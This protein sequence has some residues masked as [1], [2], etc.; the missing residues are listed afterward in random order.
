MLKVHNQHSH[1]VAARQVIG[2]GARAV[3]EALADVVIQY[4]QQGRILWCN[5][6]LGELMECSVDELVGKALPEL[7]I[8]IP[9]L[10]AGQGSN[11]EVEA[12]IHTTQGLRW[13]SWSDIEFR[14]ADG[15]I[16]RFSIARDITKSK[17]REAAFDLARE[18]AEA[19]NLDKSRLLA[20]VSHE[21]RT[22][23]NGVIGMAGLLA[24]TQLTPE[25][26]TYLDAIATSAEALV[27]L[28]GELLDFS[29]MEAGRLVLEPQRVALRGLIEGVVELLAIQAFDKQIGIGSHIS[30]EVPEAIEIDPGRLRQILLNLLGNALKFTDCGGVLVTASCPQADQLV[31]SVVDTGP[32]MDT[33]TILRLFQDFEQADDHRN[34]PD[35]GVGLGLAITKRLV[36]AMGGEIFV[37][38]TSGAGASFTIHL[39]IGLE[40]SLEASDAFAGLAVL[41]VTPW[42]MEGEALAMAVEA[43]GGTA[44]VLRDLAGV[45]VLLEGGMKKYDVLVA[46]ASLESDDRQMLSQLRN[47]GLV[48]GRALTLIAPTDR[49]RLQNLRA[50]GYDAFIARPPRGNTVLRLLNGEL[51]NSPMQPTTAKAGRKFAHSDHQLRILLAED[52][53]INVLLTEKALTNAGYTVTTVGSGLQAVDALIHKHSAYDLA[54]IDL[55]LPEIGGLEVIKRI[56]AHEADNSLP[57]M[58]IQVLSADGQKKTRQLALEYGASAFAAKPID[59][60][61]LLPLLAR[62][63]RS[64]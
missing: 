63:S 57:L 39:P 10:T 32:G 40:T 58:P 60:R 44:L 15:S 64:D 25:Q 31:L 1:R 42:I 36:E 2:T 47:Y 29:R 17:L 50:E 38:S 37:K 7:G 9:S 51:P 62:I 18:R 11:R 23:M 34:R 53:K 33:K 43:R 4:D 30:P 14:N 61:L 59:L 3:L 21:I 35:H 55:N 45:I 20:T 19:E 41:I 56:R 6:L 24:S 27:P 5:Q 48:V 8:D 16:E 46:D 12:V 49:L 13:F 28:V 54:I 52:N 26:Q 22:P